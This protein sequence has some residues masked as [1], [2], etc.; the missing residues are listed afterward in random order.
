[1]PYLT[2]KNGIKEL[3]RHHPASAR[4]LW[5]EQGF[6]AVSNEIIR[7]AKRQGVS[8]KVLPKEAFSKQFRD[9]KSHICLERDEFTYTDP[10]VFLG[11]VGLMKAPLVCAFDGIYDPQNLGNIIR[12]AACFGVDAI[13]IPKDRSCGITQ[14]VASISRGAIEHIKVVRVV[15]LARYIDELKKAGLFCY[16]L[17]E[18]GEGPVWQI[19]LQGPVCLVYGAEEGLRRL[20]RQTCDAIVKIPTV[21]AFP[22]LNVAT[23]FAVSVCEV[24]RQRMTGLPPGKG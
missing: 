5:V 14:T 20:T 13:I 12:S 21:S 24:K 15:N 2:D 1:M 3:L 23:S 22:S 11:D 10:D 6:E 17:D 7:E 18:R 19:D 8:F 9:I 16:G 4:R